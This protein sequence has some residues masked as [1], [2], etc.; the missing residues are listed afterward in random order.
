[1]HNT[2]SFSQETHRMDFASQ[3]SLQRLLNIEHEQISRCV[4]PLA[5]FPSL[6]RLITNLQDGVSIEVISRSHGSAVMCSFSVAGSFKM[7]CQR[8]LDAM[9]I[10][11]DLSMSWLLSESG[12]LPEDIASDSVEPLAFEEYTGILDLIDQELVLAVPMVA[13]HDVDSCP[14]SNLFV[15]YDKA[16]EEKRS[17]QCRN[18]AFDILQT[19]KS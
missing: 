15:E 14:A 2:Q 17:H 1:M 16:L 8:C 10:A 19:L 7:S 11:V 13:M 9:E 3:H 5:S 12:Q 4:L 18:S 6:D